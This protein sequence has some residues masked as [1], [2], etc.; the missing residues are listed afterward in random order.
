MD[1]TV[2]VVLIKI[3]KLV[4]LYI[5]FLYIFSYFSDFQRRYTYPKLEEICE[6]GLE[7]LLTIKYLCKLIIS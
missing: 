7:I 5:F 4:D 2:T 6:Y 1:E 3:L